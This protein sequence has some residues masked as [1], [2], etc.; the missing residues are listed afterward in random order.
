MKMTQPAPVVA[1][2]VAPVDAPVAPVFISKETT[3]RL[4]KDVREVMSCAELG[5]YY[6]HSETNSNND[7]VKPKSN[8][9]I[10]GIDNRLK[11]LM[12]FSHYRINKM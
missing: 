10:L 11:Y 3:M 1:P 6:K 8:K 2:V 5:I 12:T 4:L 9:V 7:C